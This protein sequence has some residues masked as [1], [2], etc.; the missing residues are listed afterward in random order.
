VRTWRE[1][2]AHRYIPQLAE[3]AAKHS[4]TSRMDKLERQAGGDEAMVAARIGPFDAIVVT[5][6]HR[7]ATSRR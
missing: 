4:E 6:A 1:R 2:S 7:G 3:V 5:A